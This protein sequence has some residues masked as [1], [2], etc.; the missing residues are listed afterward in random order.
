V[1]SVMASTSDSSVRVRTSLN[2]GQRH[3]I[4]LYR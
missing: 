1:A 4:Q 3:E 2:I